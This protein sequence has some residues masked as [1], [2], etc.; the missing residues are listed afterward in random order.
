MAGTTRTAGTE[1]GRVIPVCLFLSLESGP[2]THST[3]SQSQGKTAEADVETMEHGTVRLFAHPILSTYCRDS[4]S[5]NRKPQ[6]ERLE[7]ELRGR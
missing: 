3:C 6:R 2:S 7:G 1:T 4:L 5:F